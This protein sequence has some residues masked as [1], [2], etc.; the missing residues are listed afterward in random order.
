MEALFVAYFINGEDV[1]DLAVLD[2]IAAATAMADDAVTRSTSLKD[3][4]LK[5][6][7]DIKA[8]GLSGVP[9]YL[10]DDA[11]LFSGSRSVDGYVQAL[12][13]ASGRG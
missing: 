13:A 3:E 12:V 1:G 9:S 6:E 7:E 8:S 5:L 10:V 4:V 2:R 11:L